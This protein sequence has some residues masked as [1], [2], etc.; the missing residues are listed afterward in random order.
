[1]SERE[2]PSYLP[3]LPDPW[4]R[5]A[6]TVPTPAPDGERVA[7]TDG[8]SPPMDA[9]PPDSAAVEPPAPTGEAAPNPEAKERVRVQLAGR[10]G[11]DPKVRVTGKGTLIAQ[12]PIGIRDDADLTKTTWHTVL[13][14]QKR[15]EQ[16]RDTLKK[17]MPVEVSG[18]VHERAIPRR[19]GSTRTVRE[20]YATLIKPR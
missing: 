10:L 8:R 16:V 6:D 13:A 11:Q 1:M 12:F 3:P 7:A 19:D 15:A 20:V 18:Y 17:G 5:P 2:R 9:A 14:F 4:P